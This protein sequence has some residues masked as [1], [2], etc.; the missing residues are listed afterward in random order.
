M[1]PKALVSACWFYLTM[2][3]GKETIMGD[4]TENLSYH[5]GGAGF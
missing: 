1:T 2:C 3:E 5:S 4:N